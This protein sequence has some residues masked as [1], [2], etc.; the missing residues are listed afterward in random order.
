[1]P[2]R[3]RIPGRALSGSA[4][5]AP[6]RFRN[7]R[8]PLALRTSRLP[9]T[10][11]STRPASTP[12]SRI[13]G[14]TLPISRSSATWA[15]VYSSRPASYYSELYSPGIDPN[16]KDPR[17]Y[18]SDFTIQRNLG[19]GIFLEAGFLLQRALLARH[20]PQHQGSAGLHFRFHDPAQ[21]G[22]RYIPRDRKSTRL[23]SSHLGI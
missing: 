19:R 9:T 13:R 17:V 2:R 18:T 23:N 3:R 6:S 7:L 1:M 5:T 12:T 8:Q 20:R 22:P 16:I 15:A 10:A 4:W 11:S 14:F 21:P